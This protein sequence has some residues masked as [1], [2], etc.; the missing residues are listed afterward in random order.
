MEVGGSGYSDALADDS[1]RREADWQPRLYVGVIR[2][3]VN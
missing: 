1:L 2:Q 3:D